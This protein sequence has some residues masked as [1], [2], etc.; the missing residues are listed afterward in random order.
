M[1]KSIP[2]LNRRNVAPRVIGFDDA[3]FSTRPRVRGSE[4]HAVGVVTSADRFEGMLYCSEIEQDGLNAGDRL[5]DSV[6]NSK[7]HDQIHAVFIDGIT[8]GGLNI[9]DIQKL[10]NELDRPV[11]AVMRLPPNMGAFQEAILNLPDTEERLRRVGAAG[12][13][14][15]ITGWTFQYCCPSEQ[16]EVD[17]VSPEDVATLLNRCTPAGT[18]KIPECLRIAHLIGAAIKT[19][20]SSSSA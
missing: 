12:P 16:G 17:R 7:F 10:A 20:Q 3:P 15:E 11:I 14:H 2:E 19:G 18:Q 6:R 13:V 9:I 4:V 1:V 8:M 5:R